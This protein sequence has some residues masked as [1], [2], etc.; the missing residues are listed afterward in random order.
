MDDNLM[1][2]I[3]AIVAALL[4]LGLIFALMSSRKKKEQQLEADRAHAAELRQDTQ[5]EQAQLRQA[6]L[7]AEQRRLEA[8]Q[9]QLRQQEA[10]RGLAQQQAVQEDR[11]RTADRIDPDVDHTADDY[12]PSTASAPTQADYDNSSNTVFDDRSERTDVRGDERVDQRVDER[13]DDR[14]EGFDERSARPVQ[15]GTTDQ[16]PAA[17]GDGSVDDNLKHDNTY[18]DEDGVLRNADG[19]PHESTLR[20]RDGDGGGYGGTHRA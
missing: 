13:V 6:E 17:F 3:L 16:R 15:G 5:A 19:S 12:Q 11:L 18:V 4:I 20:D 2:I 9:A 8:E 10:E 1:W 7:E 14:S